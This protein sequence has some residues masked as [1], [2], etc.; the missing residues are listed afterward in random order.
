M[1]YIKKGDLLEIHGGNYIAASSDYTKAFGGLGG[2][3]PR[4]EDW[5]V[6]GVVDVINPLNGSR[7]TIPLKYINKVY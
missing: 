5:E 6:A 4:D 3:S 1:S 7:S 2:G